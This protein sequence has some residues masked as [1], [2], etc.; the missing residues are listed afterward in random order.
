MTRTRN[1]PIPAQM[2]MIVEELSYT[3]MTDAVGSVAMASSYVVNAL[4]FRG[5]GSVVDVALESK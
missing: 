5:E 3:G 1:A 2:P 4:P